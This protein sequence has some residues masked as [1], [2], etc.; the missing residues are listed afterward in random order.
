M[1]RI[2]LL[3]V[4][5]FPCLGQKLDFGVKGG[6]PVT[7]AFQ[8]G[9]SYFNMSVGWSASSATRRYTVGGM[10]ELQLPHGFGLECDAL[11]KRLGF[12]DVT[13]TAGVVYTYVNASANSWEFPLLAKYRLPAIPAVHPFVDAG[14]S[15]RTLS[16]VSVSTTIITVLPGV[17]AAGPFHSSDDPHF[18]SRSNAG[19]AAGLGVDFRLGRLHVAPEARYTRWRSDRQPDPQLYSTQ[20]QVELLLGI[21]S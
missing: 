2:V 7:D 3:I 20:N 19:A 15:F 6:I 4:L 5:S 12:A 11:Y 13:E 21:A 1:S 16:G 14:P 18:D 9:S 17:H 8:T 10:V